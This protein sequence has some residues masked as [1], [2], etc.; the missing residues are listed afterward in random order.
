MYVT[1]II[2]IYPSS[3]LSF[4]LTIRLFSKSVSVLFCGNMFIGSNRRITCIPDIIGYWS[5]PLDLLNLI[6]W[7]LGSSVVLKM[8][9]FIFFPRLLF[10]SVHIALFL[11]PF[12]CLWTFFWLP[13]LGYCEWSWNKHG[14]GVHVSL[15]DPVFITFE[16]TPRSG[17]AGSYGS[18]IFSFLRNLHTVFHSGCTNLYFLQQCRRVSFAPHP[19]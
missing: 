13:C 11:C 7:F 19:L 10:H 3:H 15:L 17:I 5:F 18:P 2:P 12:I 6:W 1:P 16:H 9:L 8:A 4:W 14:G